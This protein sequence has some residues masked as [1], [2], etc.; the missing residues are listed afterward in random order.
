MLVT[1]N[2]MRG[3]PLCIRFTPRKLVYKNSFLF[4]VGAVRQLWYLFTLSLNCQIKILKLDLVKCWGA[5][6][7]RITSSSFPEHHELSKQKEAWLCKE[8]WK[9]SAVWGVISDVLLTLP[10]IPLLDAEEELMWQFKGHWE[11]GATFYIPGSCIA[12]LEAAGLD[13]VPGK[14]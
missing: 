1:E 11:Q 2:T 3:F 8:E 14:T 7:D 6:L 12:Q 9:G 13:L 4:S 5:V 10:E